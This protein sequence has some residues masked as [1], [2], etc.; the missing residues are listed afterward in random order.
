MATPPPMAAAKSVTAR[1]A[2]RNLRRFLPLVLRH[3]VEVPLVLLPGV[4]LGQA[5]LGFGL[6]AGAGDV[7]LLHRGDLGVPA[8]F[9]VGAPLASRSSSARRRVALLCPG[10]CGCRRAG[11]ALLAGRAPRPRPSLAPRDAARPG[12]SPEWRPSPRFLA[13]PPWCLSSRHRACVRWSASL[14]TRL[15][16]LGRRPRELR[17]LCPVKL[18]TCGLVRKPS[19]RDS[20]RATFPTHGHDRERAHYGHDL[21]NRS[22]RGGNGRGGAGVR[23]PRVH[24]DG[25]C[26]SRPRRALGPSRR[27]S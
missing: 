19:R 14:A 21:E 7:G 3:R 27:S 24:E 6:R 26:P 11:A 22:E 1:P 2:S 23:H 15:A 13:V 17:L 8:L 12:G 25:R 10:A 20:V 16:L 18:P 5:G 4:H 9:F